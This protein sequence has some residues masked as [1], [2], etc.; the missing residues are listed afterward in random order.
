MKQKKLFLKT[1]LGAT[2]LTVFTAGQAHAAGTAAGTTVDNIFTLDYQV[3]GVA[4]DQ[5]TNDGNSGNPAPTSFTVDRVIDLS[6]ESNTDTTVTP[7]ATD[8]ELVFTL[9]NEGNDTH[10][11]DLTIIDEAA[12]DDFDASPYT[13]FYED[14]NMPGTFIEFTGAN[15]PQLDADDSIEVRIQGDIP[16][17]ALDGEAEALS[18]TATTVDAGGTAV[19]EDT[20]GNNADLSIVENVFGD[21][22]GSEE[23]TGADGSNP[24]G[25]DSAIAQ[26]IIATADLTGT[27]E[28]FMIEEN[29]DATGAGCGDLSKPADATAYS[30]PGT[31]VEYV[32][33]VSNDGS[34]AATDIAIADILNTNL[35]FVDAVTSGFDV[36]GTLTEPANGTSCDGT[37]ATC[38][39]TLTGAT[40]N[41]PALPTDPATTATLT[42]RALVK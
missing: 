10:F 6:V 36:A 19:T 29:S 42:I 7:G 38:N 16:S 18:L 4:Q 2:A 12:A 23:A 24:D 11:Y 8:Q 15:Y 20:D 37:A 28:V 14:P 21:D 3:G 41:A 30:A 40:L 39:I 34:T 35:I 25:T 13:I 22:P 5:I 33:T 32:I 31:C 9:T 26:F 17:G 1:L 27:K